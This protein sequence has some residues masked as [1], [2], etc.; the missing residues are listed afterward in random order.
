ML[1]VY[2]GPGRLGQLLVK[3]PP[4]NLSGFV[5]RFFVTSAITTICSTAKI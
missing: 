5:L 4:L 2:S 3:K 1:C